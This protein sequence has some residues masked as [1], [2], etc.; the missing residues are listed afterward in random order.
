[1]YISGSHLRVSASMWGLL[2][3]CRI[4]SK[5]IVYRRM[6][7]GRFILYRVQ[8][9]RTRFQSAAVATRSLPCVTYSISRKYS[10]E[11]SQC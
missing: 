6:N 7:K 9:R 4:D 3:F 11:K 5:N 1:M 8:L 10:L 2:G